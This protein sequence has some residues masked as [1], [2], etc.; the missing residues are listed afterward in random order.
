MTYAASKRIV[1]GFLLVYLLGGLLAR[2]ATNYQD[3]YYP[4]F[5]WFLFYRIPARDYS[6]FAVRI[7]AAGGT[8]YDPPLMFENA[9]GVYETR[10]DLSIYHNFIQSLAQAVRNKRSS[11]IET[12]RNQLEA[13]FLRRPVMYEVDEVRYNPVE[14]WQ[15]GTVHTI[16]PLA[17][18]TYGSSTIEKPSP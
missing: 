17:T 10:T 6:N 2:S 15:T 9:S 7:L 13:H 11:Q 12:F 14:R 3:E 18:F 1:V 8:T 4:F 16:T 5:S